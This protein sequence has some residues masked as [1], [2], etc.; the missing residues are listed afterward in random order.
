[1]FHSIFNR[2]D[3]SDI[4]LFVG[5]KAFDVNDLLYKLPI[6][7]LEI[8]NPNVLLGGIYKYHHPLR[9]LKNIG[10]PAIL[11]YLETSERNGISHD[12]DLQILKPS[13][14]DTYV[15]DICDLSVSQIVTRCFSI[16]SSVID[17]SM[18]F[19]SKSYPYSCRMI[20]YHIPLICEVEVLF[21]YCIKA[22]RYRLL[23]KFAQP[24]SLDQSLM[25]LCQFSNER[26][27]TQFWETEFGLIGSEI[28]PCF[29][30]EEN[31]ICGTNFIPSDVSNYT[32]TF[33]FSPIYTSEVVTEVSQDGSLYNTFCE[34]I[35]KSLY[36]S[37][38]TFLHDLIFSPRFGFSF[39]YFNEKL[40]LRLKFAGFKNKFCD[41]LNPLF[42]KGE[43]LQ[44]VSSNPEIG[45]SMSGKPGIPTI[46]SVY[47]SASS[48]P[49]PGVENAGNGEIL[50]GVSYP[51]K[52]VLNGLV[53]GIFS[54][55][56]FNDA[57][58][59]WNIG[60]TIKFISVSG[61]T[62]SV[63]FNPFKINFQGSYVKSNGLDYRTNASFVDGDIFYFK[64]I[65]VPY[66]VGYGY[67]STNEKFFIQSFSEPL[68]YLYIS[69][70]S[71]ASSNGSA[72]TL[73]D[74]QIHFRLYIRRDDLSYQ[75]KMY[76]NVSYHVVPMTSN[77]GLSDHFGTLWSKWSGFMSQTSIQ[78]CNMN[79]S[80]EQLKYD[81]PYYLKSTMAYGY[82]GVTFTSGEPYYF[83]LRR[84]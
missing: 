56:R 24:I 35:Y 74:I 54:Y 25:L 34:F 68:K 15:T 1:M 47:E 63:D 10:V 20:D 58:Y 32:S 18:D 12:V 46:L 19:V 41:T 22:F 57:I 8:N 81:T 59:S 76:T 13:S 23:N 83:T 70:S 80:S 52:V 2:D 43:R 69:D 75:E 53:N 40:Y 64:K 61:L 60:H 37:N 62:G 36:L 42:L 44:I 14:K 84:L 30:N 51:I 7:P 6:I 71:M 3:D 45:I 73:S 38:E 27:F 11:K 66:P 26:R 33:T 77:H 49:A 4:R 50:F 55:L 16:S 67:I 79:G 82:N 65:T 39:C 72:C 31:N 9:S 48:S 5:R 28:G 78:F 21:A 29:L 17:G